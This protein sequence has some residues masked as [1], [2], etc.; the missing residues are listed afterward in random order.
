VRSGTTWTEQQKLL[1]SDASSNDLFGVSV[2]VSGD[3]VVVGAYR[4]NN[5]GGVGAGAAYVLVRSGTTWTEQQKLLAS[6]AAVNLCFGYSVSV[7]GDTVAVRAYVDYNAGGV[8]AGAAYVFARSGTNWTEQQ[9][10][11]ASD[12]AA[13]DWFGYSVSV[14]G[15]TV[16][17]GAWLADAVGGV[18]AGAAYVFVRSGTT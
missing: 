14:S 7:S 4:N 18:D 15:D 17:S 10:L 16:V 5:P 9:K 6:D 8:D 3:T 2:S 12:A 1:A 13:S 11:L